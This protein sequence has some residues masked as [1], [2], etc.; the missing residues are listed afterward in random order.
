MSTI[1][2][3]ILFIIILGILVFVHEFGHFI[4]AKKMVYSFTNSPLVW[5]QPSKH[6]KVKMGLIIH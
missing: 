3:I 6:G 1:I 4:T 5:D 2:N